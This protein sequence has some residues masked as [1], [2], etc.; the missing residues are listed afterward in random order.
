MKVIIQSPDKT[1]QEK[2]ADLKVGQT[3]Q[4]GDNLGFAAD[5]ATQVIIAR[6]RLF[7]LAPDMLP[8]LEYPAAVFTITDWYP[9]NFKVG[10]TG[11]Y[12]SRRPGLAEQAAAMLE[13]NKIAQIESNRLAAKKTPQG[14]NERLFGVAAIGLVITLG[15][16]ALPVF[17]PAMI[18]GFSGGGGPDVIG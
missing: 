3:W 17:L 8:P 14:I 4:V 9:I 12:R 1:L 10:S 13:L 6:A 7:N 5:P 18:K 16:M 15:L 2:K 11:H